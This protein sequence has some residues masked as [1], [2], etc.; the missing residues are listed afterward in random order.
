M[1]LQ[2]D[3]LAGGPPRMS[4]LEQTWG[5]IHAWLA[6]HCPVVLASLGP[7]ATD[8]QFREA[9]QAMG[10]ELPEEVKDCY[11]TH[12]GQ[13]IIPTPASYWPDLRCIP[14]FLYAE[15]W[16]GLADMVHRWGMM[17]KL[18]DGGTFRG[19]K[20]Q[21]RGPVRTDWW[22]PKWLPLTADDSGYMKCLDLAPKSRG[23]VGQVIFW[24]HDSPERGVLAKSL[25]EWLARFA[26]QLE[27]GE[28]TTGPDKHGPGLIRVR[29]L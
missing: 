10:V 27:Q 5:R 14:A 19:I 13:R 24:C 28:Y 8:E 29:D 23:S 7:P 15:K 26:L 16:W 3:T 25:P 22:H 6:A 11:R 12:D 9:E 17:K 1:R 21:P 18:I 4:T 2:A 20:G